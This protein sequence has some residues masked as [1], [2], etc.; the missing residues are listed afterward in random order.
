VASII[1]LAGETTSSAIPPPPGEGAPV[2]PLADELDHLE[3]L[4]CVAS[5][6]FGGRKDKLMSKHK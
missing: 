5:I 6:I 3:E 1:F 4:V 2:R